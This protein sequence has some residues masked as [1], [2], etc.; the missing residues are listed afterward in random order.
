MHY[1]IIGTPRAWMIYISAI[2]TCIVGLLLF[3]GLAT[4]WA[5]L[6]A[7]VVVLKHAFIFRNHPAR[8]LPPSTY[9]LLAIIAATLLLSGAGLK[10][11]DLPL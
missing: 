11:F 8:P 3:V 10:A 4:Q 6:A 1:P 9:I 5:A 7:I 2:L